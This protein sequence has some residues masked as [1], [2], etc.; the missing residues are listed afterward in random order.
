MP[1][2]K[3]A[4]SSPLWLLF[5]IFMLVGTAGL[6]V[7]YVWARHLGHVGTFCDI[8]DLVVHLPERILFRM[9]FSFVGVFLAFA[10]FPIKSMMDTRASSS[11][12]KHL[13]SFAQVCQFCSGFG[14]ALV[15]ACGPEEIFGLHLLAAVLGFGGSAMAQVAFNFVLYYEDQ[16][17][18]P[19]SAGKLFKVRC[20]ISTVFF[21]A[22]IILG[23]GELP[24]GLPEPTERIAEWSLW[25]CLMAWYFTFKQDLKDYFVGAFVQDDGEEQRGVYMGVSLISTL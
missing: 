3:I 17:T 2:Q 12:M 14:V 10:S 18:M 20:A 6:G 21:I 15:G 24:N 1:S 16:V 23:L 4:K 9:N 8:S 5:D 22:A 19:D 25:F 11:K 7:C 13:V